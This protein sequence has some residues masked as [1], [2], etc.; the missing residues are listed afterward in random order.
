MEERWILKTGGEWEH[1]TEIVGKHIK[2]SIRLVVEEQLL[3]KKGGEWKILSGVA[4]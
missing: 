4:G 3:W 1:L 2:P